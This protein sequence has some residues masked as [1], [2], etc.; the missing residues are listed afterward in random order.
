MALDGLFSFSIVPI[1]IAT[2]LGLA[3]A[4]FSLLAVVGAIVIKLATSYAPQGWTSLMIVV[5]FLGGVQLIFI[6]VLGEYICRIYEEVKNRPL[7]LIREKIG[8]ETK[9]SG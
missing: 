8:F 2:Y 1:R 9:V 7:Y 3:A 6:G 4:G 5:T